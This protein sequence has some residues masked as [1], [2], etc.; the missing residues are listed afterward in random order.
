MYIQALSWYNWLYDRITDIKDVSFSY[1]RT[2]LGPEPQKIYILTNGDV[3][4][5]SMTMDP[6]FLEGAFLYTPEDKRLTRDSGLENRYR[7]VGYLSI[8]IHNPSIRSIDLSDWIGSLRM[9][10]QIRIDVRMYVRLWS[11]LTNTYIPSKNTTLD[12]VDN[13]GEQVTIV[14]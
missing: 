7:P 2:Y 4:L 11:V 6:T 1:A 8:V 13:M 12:V 14:F 3:V 9:N 5:H 10:P